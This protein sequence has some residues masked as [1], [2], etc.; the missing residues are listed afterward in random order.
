[1]SL[2]YSS[3][4]KFFN[5]CRENRLAPLSIKIKVLKSCVMSSLLYN[6]ETFGNRIPIGLETLYHKLLRCALNV[7]SNTPTLLMY[8]ETGLLPIRALIEARQLKYFKRFPSTISPSSA[9]DYLFQSL[10]NDPSSYLKHYYSLQISMI[11]NIRYMISIT[12]R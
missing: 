4:I 6:C 8:I 11:T 3:C 12:I 1:M 7:R 5:F 9:R 10:N 2:R